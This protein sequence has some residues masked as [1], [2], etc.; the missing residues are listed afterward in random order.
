MRSFFLLLVVSFTLYGSPNNKDLLSLIYQ[1]SDTLLKEVQL[2]K[3]HFGITKE[4][5]P[6]KIN[7][8]MLTRHTRGRAYEIFSKVN[9]L[10][11]K[12]GLP[13]VEPPNMEP[14]TELNAKY[15]YG[16]LERL[17]AEIHIL[18]FHF[19]IN[20]KVKPSKISSHKTVADTYNYLG[21][22]SAELDTING[23]AFTPSHV[24]SEAMRIYEDMGAILLHLEK[25]DYTIPPRKLKQAKPQDTYELALDLLNTL[26]S[27]ILQSGIKS[28]DFYAFERTNV[29]PSD[30]YEITQLILSELQVIKASIG[31]S[32]ETTRGAV[33]TVG[34]TPADAAQ[35]MGWLN[36][37]A[38]LIKNL[39]QRGG[40]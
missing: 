20:K 18:K 13:T 25:D 33:Y 38:E 17:L 2:I 37:K 16:Q 11:V 7:T 12:N 23:E 3:K 26:K 24:F 27:L 34:K 36:A 35:V 15:T 40:K 32:H 14:T 31:L 22:V 21:R 19:G 1:Q 10:R 39:H 8:K 4:A 9:I 6:K 30:V 29:T 5:K 28:I